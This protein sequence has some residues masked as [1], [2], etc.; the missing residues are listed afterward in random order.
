MAAATPA[1]AQR[2]RS[3]PVLHELIPPDPREDVAL[4]LSLAGDIP[5]GIEGPRGMI[6]APDPARPLPQGGAPYQ[7]GPRTDGTLASVPAKSA[8]SSRTLC[9]SI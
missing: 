8:T 5:A 7:P 2:T 6:P 1:V 9:P 4:S 3:G